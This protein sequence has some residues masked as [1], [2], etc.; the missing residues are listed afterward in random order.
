MIAL[1]G[2]FLIVNL[3]VSGRS[4][5][6]LLKVLGIPDE[7]I[8]TFDE[9]DPQAQFQNPDEALAKSQA[10]AIVLSPGYPASTP[11]IQKAAAQGVVITSEIS[12]A[13]PHLQNEIKIG[14]TGSVG[15]STTAALFYVGAKREDPHSFL[16]G[17]FGTPLADYAADVLE[18]KRARAKF[19]IIEISSYQLEN[20]KGLYFDYA[21]VTALNENHLERYNSVDHYYLTKLSLIFRTHQ[22]IVLNENGLELF[23]YIKKLIPFYPEKGIQIGQSDFSIEDKMDRILLSFSRSKNIQDLIDMRQIVATAL[24]HHD[25]IGTVH[26]TV[27]KVGEQCEVVGKHNRDN[28]SAAIRLGQILGFQGSSLD[29]IRKFRGL[30]HRIENLGKAGGVRF[31]NDSKSTTIESVLVAIEACRDFSRTGTLF[32]LLG[33]R[34]KNLPWKKLSTFQEATN[35]EFVFFGECA[36]HAAKETRLSN[37]IH[38]TLHA[39]LVWCKIKAQVHDTIL[40]SPGGTSLDEFKNFEERGEFFK[41]KMKDFSSK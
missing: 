15:K 12:L 21:I 14:I 16:G 38:K 8:F 34:D 41:T 2:P 23:D 31:I 20:A 1:Q 40:L 17:N 5:I 25:E 6:R 36:E 19:L 11:W 13:A 9:K 37:N 30:S 18:K 24:K 22:A 39:A 4:A 29:E 26:W 33:G 7:R 27:A 10:S 35:M 3:G 28:L 32:I